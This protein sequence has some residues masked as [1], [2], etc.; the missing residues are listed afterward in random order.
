MLV[1]TREEA[2][3]AYLVYQYGDHLTHFPKSPEEIRSHVN[4]THIDSIKN[5]SFIV[6]PQA[7]INLTKLEQQ[8][9][10]FIYMMAYNT[11]GNSLNITTHTFTTQVLSNAAT[12]KITTR[13]FIETDEVKIV[14]A[15]A[16][17]LKID[18][19][20]IKVVSS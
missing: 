10:Y 14:K 6:N 20:R 13:N 19:Y 9:Q 15:L 18:P 1:H 16:D 3:I 4:S 5:S 2:I 11:L 12:F 8:T 17:I 7:F